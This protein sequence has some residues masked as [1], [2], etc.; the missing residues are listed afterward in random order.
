VAERELRDPHPPWLEYSFYVHERS[1]VDGFADLARAAVDEGATPVEVALYRSAGMRGRLAE[2]LLEGWSE[3]PQR[4]EAPAVDEV[5]TLLRDRDVL[6][7]AVDL[8]NPEGLVPEAREEIRFCDPY[9]IE[10]V[11]AGQI[12]FELRVDGEL[13]DFASAAV[14][15][16]A[17]MATYERLRRLCEA[18]RPDY[19][20]CAEEENVAALLD[21]EAFAFTDFYVRTGFVGEERARRLRALYADAFVEDWADGFFVSTWAPGNPA[22]IGIPYEHTRAIRAG[23]IIAGLE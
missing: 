8:E 4:L 10:A 22:G 15:A 13:L 21:L 7:I 23:R 12:P 16:K 2:S 11:R 6:V 5:E 9:E 1:P 17:G 14:L 19:A 18:V 20:A 3:K